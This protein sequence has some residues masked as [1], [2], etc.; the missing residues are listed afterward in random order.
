MLQC[1]FSGEKDKQVVDQ[2]GV[3][4]VDQ[5]GEKFVGAVNEFVIG[6]L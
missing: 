2:F 1:S 5:F 6:F 4:V 3:M